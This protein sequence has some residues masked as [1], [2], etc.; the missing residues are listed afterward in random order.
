[1]RK[2]LFISLF[3]LSFGF[4]S[5]YRV[6]AQSVAV[7]LNRDYYHLIERYQVRSRYMLTDFA[8]KPWE[9]KAVAT[10]ADNLLGSDS[11]A[12]NSRDYFN[13]KFLAQDNWEWSSMIDPDA[14]KPLMKNFYQKRSDFFFYGDD[15][16]K[17]HIS[18]VFH[19]AVGQENDVERET[20]INTRGVEARGQIAGS[21]GFYSYVGENQARFPVYGREFIEQERF[22]VPGE[23]FWK[24]FK[25]GGVDF[26]TGRA[27]ITFDP[28][29][30][31]NVR[32]GYDR[33]FLGHG[34]RSLL[35]SDFSNNFLLLNFNTRI[36]QKIQYTNLFTELR[37][38]A[39]AGR[40]GSIDGEFP[41]KYMTI[42]RIGYDVLPNLNIG[43]FEQ[44][45]FGDDN[46]NR[47]PPI[48]VEYF[49]PII[50]ARSV[51]NTNDPNENRA[52]G[53]DA[54]WNVMQT[55]SVYG[56]LYLDNFSFGGI[57]SGKWDQNTAMQAGVKYF[58]VAK[59][60]NLDIQLEWNRIS[61]FTY[62]SRNYLL[63]M[64]HYRQPLAH[65]MGA[66]LNELIA[67]VRFQPMERLFL[68]A[69]GIF[70]EFG[71]DLPRKN[72]GGD[73]T[74]STDTRVGDEAFLTQGNYSRLFNVQLTA[75]YMIKHNLFLDMRHQMRQLTQEVETG[76]K[77]DT[78]HS[79]IS[80][81][82]NIP[83][84]DHEF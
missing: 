67:V 31:M 3:F 30:A 81:R 40:S 25:E 59:I 63:D 80:L 70:T 51:F 32:F 48:K 60:S 23:G 16:F 72:F 34:H 12:L 71:S 58:D 64:T 28:I 2:H 76:K 77:L 52:L 56:T 26:L 74:K 65:P 49:N 22:A 15:D 55:A 66:N 50:F 54:R 9:R 79:M 6:Q 73:P 13:L 82:L 17:L 46:I 53:I 36:G 11:I 18:P 35:L 68:N 7:P 21:L 19:F 10:L 83:H 43:L 1:M 38:T 14:E 39:F 20:F 84:R 42:H 29:Q 45:V 24:D 33:H 75:S 57:G 47:P 37:A 8:V 78:Q 41:K 61:P 27:Y 5:A 44:I 62:A 4:S 69:T